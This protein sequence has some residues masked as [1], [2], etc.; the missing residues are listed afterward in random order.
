MY[1]PKINLEK[2][3][4]EI[5]DFMKQFSFATII[6]SRN[7]IPIATHLPFVVRVEGEEIVL[8]SHF[9][10][11]NGQWKDLEDNKVL[12]IFTEPHAY[13]S[14]KHYDEGFNIPTWNYI[15]VH[16]YGQGRII[17]DTNET[18]AVIKELIS[19]YEAEYQKELDKFPEDY[20]LY[21]L[22]GLV[23]FE[24][25]VTDLQARKKLSQNRNE[26]E[27]DRII[28]A[29]SKSNNSQQKLIADYMTRMKE[30]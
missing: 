17:T 7:N 3:K 12:V 11:A 26:V 5:V 18:L 21:K 19:N 10:R 24:V 27:R 28:E 29:L 23:A 6:T 9:A 15:S 14:T 25:T 2:D 16:A 1:V 4:L 13:I 20:L 30:K 22:G 8:V